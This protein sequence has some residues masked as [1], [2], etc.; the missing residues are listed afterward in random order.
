MDVKPTETQAGASGELT[1]PAAAER[2]AERDLED[3][4]LYFNRELSWLEFNDRVLQLAEDPSVPLLERVRFCAIWESNL[5]EFFMVRVANL[6]DHVEAGRDARG[7]DGMSANEQIAAIVERVSAQRERVAHCFE[8]E[9]RPALSEHG[10]RLIS[11]DGTTADEKAELERVFRNQVFPVLTPLVIGSGRPFP[12]ISNL[13]L[14]LAVVLRDPD[15]D[16]EVLARV[17]VPKE[18]LRRFIPVDEE[19]SALVALDDLIAANLGELFPGMEVLEHSFFRVIRDTDY[20][21]SDEADDLLQAVEEELR[22]RRFGEVVRLEVAADMPE[23]PARAARR[24]AG[25][26]GPSGLRGRGDARPLGP[27]RRRRQ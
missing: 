3:P 7:P 8:R 4:S 19:G 27:L 14:S 10:I 15:Q 6:H 13:S 2:A 24:R 16:V 22:R 5:D 17:K 26:R 9:I 11:V 1:Q 12:Y 18:L 21:V 25:D 23:S 20:D